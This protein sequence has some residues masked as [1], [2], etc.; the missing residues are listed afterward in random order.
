MPYAEFSPT[1]RASLSSVTNPRPHVVTSAP[2]ITIVRAQECPS[3][4][5]EFVQDTKKYIL[6][7]LRGDETAL[8]VFFC[9]RLEIAKNRSTPPPPMIVSTATAAAPTLPTFS[10]GQPNPIPLTVKAPTI[11]ASSSSEQ[12]QPAS[13]ATSALPSTVV[14]PPVINA[15]SATSSTTVLPQSAS[16]VAPA[17]STSSSSTPAVF[18][19]QSSDLLSAAEQEA[20]A[21]QI[22]EGKQRVLSPPV[23]QAEKDIR[24][25]LF[26]DQ[27]QSASGMKDQDTRAVGGELDGLDGSKDQD[28]YQESEGNQVAGTQ[29]QSVDAEDIA[30]KG[31]AASDAAGDEAAAQDFA[32]A[33]AATNDEADSWDE[34][35]QS[36]EPLGS[37]QLQDSSA[38]VSDG[39]E[40]EELGTGEEVAAQ[41]AVV[42]DATIRDEAH[43]QGQL[44]QTNSLG[45]QVSLGCS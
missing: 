12:P 22:R 14:T 45:S 10:W 36:K 24:R 34:D 7:Q 18:A 6:S 2:P 4:L 38:P 3:L 17:Q 30:I 27:L 37:P 21:R 40:E 8:F 1:R 16:I 35:T 9:R 20:R 32:V 42:E 44:T 19:E 43:S 28:E 11:T 31:V 41:D 5:K 13:P 23:N 39:A 15:S 29:E 33:A 26:G 25:I